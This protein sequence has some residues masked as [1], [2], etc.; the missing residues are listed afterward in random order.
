M[1]S[2]ARHVAA[3][4]P[5][6]C[7]WRRLWRSGAEDGVVAPIR[8]SKM[9]S[10]CLDRVPEEKTKTCRGTAAAAQI[11][12]LEDTWCCD[13]AAESFAETV[14]QVVAVATTGRV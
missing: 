8:T 1:I 13:M 7:I 5:L 9:L 11:R 6:L 2:T 10:W 4:S 14:E 3:I 12:A